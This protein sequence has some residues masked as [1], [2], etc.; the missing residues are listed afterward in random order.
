V[1]RED[2]TLLALKRVDLE[3]L[4]ETAMRGYKSE[5]ELLQKLAHVE[6][7]VNLKDWELNIEKQTLSLVC[8]I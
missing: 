1:L 4:D 5:I 7:V 2:D 6:R 3:Y 8:F